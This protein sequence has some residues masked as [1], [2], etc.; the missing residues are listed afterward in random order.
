MSTLAPDR[1]GRNSPVCMWGEALK[2]A[3]QGVLFS[4]AV[5]TSGRSRPTG[6][7][8]LRRTPILFTPGGRNGVTR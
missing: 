7:R 3:R 5:K 1:G 2:L 4:H 8:M 6:L